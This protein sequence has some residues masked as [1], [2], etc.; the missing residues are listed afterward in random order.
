[1]AGCLFHF[2]E[3]RFAQGEVVNFEANFTVLILI[4]SGCAT[5]KSDEIELEL[6]GAQCGLYRPR[7]RL[8]ITFQRDTFV[9]V[10]RCS[11]WQP[12]EH[13]A[14]SAPQTFPLFASQ[15]V[16]TLLRL[17]TELEP[18]A[19]EA[20]IR[21]RN[22]IGEAVLHAYNNQQSVGTLNDVPHMISNSKSYI[23]EHLAE[24][25]DLTALARLAGMSKAHYVCAFRKHFGLTPIRFL[26]HARARKAV[27][28]VQTTNLNLADISDQCGYKSQY[29]LSREIKRLTGMSPRAMRNAFEAS[30]YLVSAPYA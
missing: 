6:E 12:I 5:V 24:D 17:G 28:L 11:R 23:E 26:W 4:V 29:H 18:P 2:D 19:T 3:T 30:H 7:E 27:D 1:V 8:E 10:L 15:T 22:A 16:A 14:R 20:S 13:S 21:L 25:C 9:Q